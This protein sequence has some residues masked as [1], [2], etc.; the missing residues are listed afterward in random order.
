MSLSSFP[1]VWE[2]INALKY[3]KPVKNIKLPIKEYNL[4]KLVAFWLSGWFQGRIPIE[5]EYKF[6]NGRVDILVGNEIAIEIKI[7]R[8]MAQLKNLLGEIQADKTTFK[9]VI[10]YVVDT[11]GYFDENLARSVIDSG[12]LSNPRVYFVIKEGEIKRT[13]NNKYLVLKS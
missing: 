4:Q 9:Y 6:R 5:L 10:A 8:G 12:W 11:G 3:F 2:V 7:L 1:T 13:G